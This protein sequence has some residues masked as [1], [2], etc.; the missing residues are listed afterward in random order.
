MIKWPSLKQLHYLVTLHETRHFSDAAERC[1]VSQSTLSKGIQ[2]L[3]ALIGCPLFEKKDKK[4][5][6]VFTHA[7]EQVVKRSRELLARGQDLIELGKQCQGGEMEGQLKLGCIPTIAPFLLCDLVQE[8]NVRYPNL[9]LLLREDTTANLLTALRNGELD[10]LILALPMEIGNMESRV[11][12]QDPFRMVISRH[13]ADGIRVPIK[14]DDLPDESVFLLE[15]EHCLTEHAVSACKLTD[16]EKINP[17]TATS[18]HTLVQMVANGLGTTFIPQM[19]IEHGLLDNQNLVVIDPP[20]QQAYR[21]IGLVWRP[22]SSRSHTF[23]RLADVVSEL[24]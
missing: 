14:Y 2:N 8:V 4:S 22:S 15:N 13:Q 1:F 17:F 12:G 11:V 23:E 19:A 6:L 18:L 21:E 3:E 5:P 24:L 16:K 20:G 9:H 10:V 7:G